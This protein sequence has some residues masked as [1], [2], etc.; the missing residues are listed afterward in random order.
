MLVLNKEKVKIDDLEK[1][2][3]DIVTT[4]E[5]LEADMKNDKANG[6]YCVRAYKKIGPYYSIIV[7]NDM[8]A[9]EVSIVPEGGFPWRIAISNQLDALY[10]LINEGIIIKMEE[11]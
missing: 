5:D 11:K 10:D 3:F 9:D 8:Y 7:Q 6:W 2:G 1:Y 4:D